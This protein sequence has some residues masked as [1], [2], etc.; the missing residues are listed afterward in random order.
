M[1]ARRTGYMAE[2]F[3]LYLALQHASVPADVIDE[4]MLTPQGLK[5]YRV[6]Y[7]TGPDVPKEAQQALLA[8]V[9][10]GG[11]LVLAP[12]AAHW[13][14][15]HQPCSLVYEAAGV[16]SAAVP[17]EFYANVRALAIAGSGQG[18]QGAFEY[19]G[20]RAKLTHRH[21]RVVA[22]FADGAAAV[23]VAEV[24]KGKV[25]F[26]AW[27]PG[28]SYWRSWRK[29]SDGLPV[30]FSASLRRWIVWPALQLAGIQPPARPS[31][32]MVE[33]LC[34]HSPRGVAVT[35]LNWSGQRQLPLRLRLRLDF[36]PRRV[37]AAVARHIQLKPVPQGIELQW[38]LGRYE[39][40]GL[41]R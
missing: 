31:V 37:K 23:V 4:D 32:P 12:G 30:G 20:P 38:T 29:R 19:V 27:W 6:V 14:R 18:E 33:A 22:R 36:R 26:F 28:L 3:D 25:V 10:S 24:G 15:Y 13:D 40:L 11:V 9:R 1:N 35:V 7:L 16:H 21:G 34:L 41:Y 5:P 39:V 17:R 2:L 8:W